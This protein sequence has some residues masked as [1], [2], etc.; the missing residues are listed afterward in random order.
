M[1][2]RGDGDQVVDQRPGDRWQGAQGGQGEG[3]AI[4]ADGQGIAFPDHFQGLL[5]DGQGV[6]RLADPAPL[7]D[8][9]GVLDGDI[10]APVTD[11]QAEIGGGKGRGVVDPVAD[12][13]DQIGRV[14]RAKMQVDESLSNTRDKYVGM[15]QEAKADIS[16]DKA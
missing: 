8:D 9:I 1:G 14:A 3:G 16:T 12:H 5:A 4:E 6:G 13:G 2:H 11:G 10:G 7:Q 15:W